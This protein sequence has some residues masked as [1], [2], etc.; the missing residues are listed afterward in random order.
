MTLLLVRNNINLLDSV[1]KRDNHDRDILPERGH[2]LMAT[3]LKPR[4]LLIDFGASNHMVANKYSLSFLDSNCRIPIHMGDDSQIISKGKGTVN[5]E[6]RK[7]F[8]VLY[9]PSLASNMLSVYQMAHVGVTNIFY[10]STNGV[11]IS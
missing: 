1:R 9:V 10:F 4:A 5:L 3:V 11:Y 8:D 2:A 7:F 6:H